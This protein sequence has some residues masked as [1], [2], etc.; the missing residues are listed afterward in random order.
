MKDKHFIN[1]T[2]GIEAIEDIPATEDIHFIRIQSTTIERHYWLK[3]FYELDYNFLMYIALGYNC[4]FYDY[5]TNR[6]WSKTCYT[7]I[8]LI[9]YCL[10][11]YWFNNETPGI[12][13]SRNG[14]LI[15]GMDDDY[16]HIYNELFVYNSTKEKNLLKAKLKYFKR[17]L[18]GDKCNFTII[19]KSTTNDN[20]WKYYQETLNEYL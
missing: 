5:G 11:R 6:P 17:F 8:P 2:N 18:R 13:Y 1:L 4:H 9:E 12:R 14:T 19:S 16:Q 3:L 10:N 7:A 20:N 15:Q